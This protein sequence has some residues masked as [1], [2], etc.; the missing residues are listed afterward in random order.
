V[1][2]HG[3]KLKRCY[4][5]TPDSWL[6]TPVT[7][8]NKDTEREN[9]STNNEHHEVESPPTATSYRARQKTSELETKL[10]FK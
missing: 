1:P 7:T 8:S 4:D 3:D 10:R 6:N 5:N 2:N 9:T